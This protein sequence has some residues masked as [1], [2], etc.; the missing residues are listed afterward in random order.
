MTSSRKANAIENPRHGKMIEL[1]RRASTRLPPVTRINQADGNRHG[2]QPVQDQVPRRQS[3]QKEIERLAEN[4]VYDAAR[5]LRRIPEK[6]KRRP[7]YTHA[8]PG[9]E[10][11]NNRQAERDES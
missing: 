11:H 1:L 2:Q 5:G 9:D 10:S 4:W 8:R 6:R 7:L 3:E